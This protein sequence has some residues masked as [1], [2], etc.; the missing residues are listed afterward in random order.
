MFLR[1]YRPDDKRYLQQLFFHTV[2]TVNAR[3]YSSEQL[4]ALAPVE[5]DRKWWS[6]LDEAFCFVVESRKIL[7]GFAAV[8]AD[9]SLDFLYVHPA[10]QGKGIATALYKQL[11]RLAR[12]REFAFI[13]AVA[14]GTARGFF[15][16]KGFVVL[17]E[18]RETK[19]NVEFL[20]YKMV[21]ALIK[22][23]IDTTLQQAQTG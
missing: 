15:E 1:A 2:H 22:P 8:S 10:Y 19:E 4:A 6:R 3:D 13:Q 16:K 18:I 11:E 20:H 14:G 5:P 23:V 7:V 17:D 12:K 21:K 9:G